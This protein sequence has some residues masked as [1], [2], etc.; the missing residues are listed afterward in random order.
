[1]IVS[2]SMEKW[3]FG[4]QKGIWSDFRALISVDTN[5]HKNRSPSIMPDIPKLHYSNT[6]RHLVAAKPIF[7]DVTRMTGFSVLK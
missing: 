3:K 7:P 6:P 1:M 5:K 2:K 4:V